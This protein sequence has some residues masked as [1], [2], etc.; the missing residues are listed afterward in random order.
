MFSP[1][2]MKFLIGKDVEEHLPKHEKETSNKPDKDGV[3]RYK[4]YVT[5]PIE[6]SETR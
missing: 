1:E 6:V 5:I 3:Y 2:F 4:K